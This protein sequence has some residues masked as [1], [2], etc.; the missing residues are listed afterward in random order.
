LLG[1]LEFRRGLP[2]NRME[3]SKRQRKLDDKRQ[4]RQARAV[5]DVRSEPL[6]ANKRLEPE[7]EGSGCSNVIL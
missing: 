1:G 7:I 2:R 4:Q 3:M 6:H 5:F